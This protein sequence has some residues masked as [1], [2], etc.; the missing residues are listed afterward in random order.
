MSFKLNI[1]A[2]PIYELLSSFMIYTTRRWIAN[3]D[4]TSA[5]IDD[6][7][8]LLEPG[9]LEVLQPA[10]QWPFSDYDILF[11]WA[12]HRQ[13]GVSVEKFLDDLEHTPAAE[14]TERI[15]TL[16]PSLTAKEA[17][18]I[19]SRYLPLLRLWHTRYFSGIAREMET[20]LLEDAEDKR[21]LLS[22][23][24]PSAFIEYATGGLVMDAKLHMKEVILLPTVHF[25]PLNTYCFYNELLCI[26]YPLD[27]SEPSGKEPPSILLRLTQALASSE[28]LRLLRIV[29]EGP[30]TLDEIQAAAYM[31]EELVRQHLMQ[32]RS[33]GLLRIHLEG[34]DSERI[35]IRRDGAAELQI[36]LETYI[37]L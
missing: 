10:A 2:S 30:K 34:P 28:R 27:E 12:I 7:E 15:S 26:Q 25:K 16:L 1:D 35:G 21:S 8:A 11:A 5:W 29:A 3:L 31:P 23:M 13:A 14:L 4:L 37:G 9:E 33:A 17:E 20:A 24:E 18:M 32:L 19:R 36:F 6:I 22:K